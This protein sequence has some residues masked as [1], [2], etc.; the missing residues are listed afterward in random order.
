MPPKDHFDSPMERVAFAGLVKPKACG[1]KHIFEQLGGNPPYCPCFK[2]CALELPKFEVWVSLNPFLGSDVG[3]PFYLWAEQDLTS[4]GMMS[5][6]M[7]VQ[8]CGPS[9]EVSSVPLES[10]DLSSPPG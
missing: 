5:S 8:Q 10:S 4:L 2:P 7:E 9:P 6:D 1:S 3:Y